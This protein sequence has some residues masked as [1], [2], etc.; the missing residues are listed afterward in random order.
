MFNGLPL[1]ENKK[2]KDGERF[3]KTII[4]NDIYQA[5]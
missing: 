2:S 5:K 1:L 4:Y 3:I